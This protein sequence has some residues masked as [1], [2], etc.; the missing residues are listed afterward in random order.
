VIIART[1]FRLSLAFAGGVAVHAAPSVTR[2]TPPSGLFSYGDPSPPYIARFLPGQ[3]FDLQATIR[4]DEGK[5]IASVEFLVDQVAVPGGIA[6]TPVTV[7]GVAEGTTVATRRGFSVTAPGVHTLT[8]RARQVD[9]T[10]VTA[11]G[12]FEIVALTAETGQK[13]RN[14]IILIGDGMGIAHRTAARLMLHGATQG[15]ALAPLAMDTFPATALVQTAS[16]DSIV[17]DSAPGAAAYSTGNKNHNNEEGVFPDDTKDKFDNPRIELIGEYLARTQGKWLGIVTTADVTDA[18]PGAFGAHT[19]D[20]GAG[21]GIADQFLDETVAKSHLRVLLGGGRRWFLPDTTLGSG[22]NNE[23]DYQLP[24]EAAT[25]WGVRAGAVDPGRNLLDDFRAAGFTYA[26]NNTQLKAV[27]ADTS[28]LLG[29]FQLGN[30]NAA[31]DKIGKRRG[32]TAVLDDFGFPDQPMLDEMTDAALA[33]LKQNPAGFVLMIEGASIDKQAHSMDTE[34][35]LHEVI[36]FDRAVARAKAFAQAVPGTLVIVTADHETGGVNVIGASM[37]SQADLA[38]RGLDGGVTGLRDEVVGVYS[39]A[40]FPNYKILA[41]GYPETANVDRRML[42]GYAA[43]GDRYENWQTNPKPIGGPDGY[44]TNALE[45]DVSGGYLITGQ[46][47]GTGAVHTGSDVP[48]S[49]FGVG[50][51]AFSGVLDNTDVFFKTMQ[52]A[53]G[54]TPGGAILAM[55]APLGQRTASDRLVN[56]S[57]RGLVGSGEGAM[58]NGFVLAGAQAH[59]LL[60]RGVGP[61]LAS[62]GVGAPLANPMLRLANEFNATLE[63]NDD[64]GA[65]ANPE[66][67]SNAAKAVGAFALPAGSK[68][69]ALLVTLPPGRYTV[70]LSGGNGT[71]GVGLLEVYELP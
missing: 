9:G 13:A 11:Q 35:W 36:E 61:T 46:I 24:A 54:G 33:V 4:P 27:A 40:G 23:S 52:L 71:S 60:I 16:L 59:R 67:V 66:A 1:L 37:V 26:S 2:L 56:L 43:N 65:G 63:T 10:A 39:A 12:N 41:D 8:V 31:L 19:Q 29:L 51:S 45:R 25:G 6:L 53:I 68:D 47:P 49:A 55:A 20:R 58:F 18:T 17:T 32:R 44:P 70:E 62:Y 28:R 3:R 21:A 14:V 57:S 5:T 64:W 30:L 48:L 22:R 38:R 34:R 42:I 15:K 50:A 7:G 69:A